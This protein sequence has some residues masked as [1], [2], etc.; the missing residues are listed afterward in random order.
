MLARR[1]HAGGQL[2][3]RRDRLTESAGVACGNFTSLSG[4]LT[5]G[6]R[7][8]DMQGACDSDTFCY[9]TTNSAQTAQMNEGVESFFTLQ[10]WGRFLRHDL[11]DMPRTL[12]AVVG[13]TARIYWN[14][15]HESAG[16]PSQYTYAVSG[17]GATDANGWSMTPV[18]GDVGSRTITI[19]ASLGGRPVATRSFT[20]N[21]LTAATTGTARIVLV[22]DSWM[23]GFTLGDTIRANLVADG[24]TVTTLASGRD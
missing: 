8:S 19:V 24:L 22:G 21:V 7:V 16:G 6:A 5:V 10:P 18:G 13:R 14:Q 9:V 17:G 23:N 15:V 20:L 4:S 12:D 2:Y 3:I 1:R 11:V